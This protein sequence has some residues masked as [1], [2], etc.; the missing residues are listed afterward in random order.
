MHDYYRIAEIS[1]A[2]RHASR[3]ARA[4]AWPIARPRAA[5]ARR[6]AGMPSLHLVRALE[7]ERPLDLAWR[8]EV[9]LDFPSV[10]PA[11]DR[12][13]RGFVDAD[14]PMTRVSTAVVLPAADLLHGVRVPI[15]LDVPVVCESCGGRGEAWNEAC[16]PC[17]GAGATRAGRYI[18]V[19]VP[20]GS[21]EGCLCY[22]LSLPYGPPVRLDVHVARR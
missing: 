17:G 13:C 2:S 18:V 15:R 11:V 7:P 3:G 16:P 14:A 19:R 1:A 5:R 20:A 6:A 12:M 8:D 22:R 4:W 10:Q 21:V 9:A